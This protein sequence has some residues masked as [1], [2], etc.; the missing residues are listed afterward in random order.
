LRVVKSTAIPHSLGWYYAAFTAYM[1]FIPYRHEGKLMALAGLGHERA[2]ENPWPDRLDEILSVSAGDYQVDPT[3]TRFGAHSHAERFTDK[4]IDFVT[5]FD[6]KLKPLGFR[7]GRASER[8]LDPDYVDL[9]WGVQRQLERA[10]AEVVKGSANQTAS[11]NL[12]IAGGV[13]MNC[14]MN[15]SLLEGSGIERVYGFPACHDAGASIG[16]AMYVASQGGDKI[17][18]ELKTA[19]LGPAFS[20]DEVREVL[21][22]S[23]VSFSACDDIAERS[24]KLLSEGKLMG[25]FQG[26]M[27]MGPR[28]LGGRSILADPNVSGVSD[29]LNNEVKGRETWRPFCP[30]ILDDKAADHFVGSEDAAFMTVALGV[31]EGA[32]EGMKETMH[33]DGTARPQVVHE[34]ASPIYH[35]LLT[36]FEGQTGRPFLLNTSFNVSGEPIVCSPAEALRSFY[37]CGLDALAIGDFLVEKK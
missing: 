19:Q 17:K 22:F 25:W 21:K 7:D 1:G 3:Y 35:R 26:R 32:R 23:K 18:R 4:L 31:K 6:P 11:R 10:A 29:K 34:A 27:E 5:G 28:A 9:A 12:C 36:Q 8:L 15:G 30:S 33:V 16:A 20:N 2:A 14:K 37:A 24:A 13:G